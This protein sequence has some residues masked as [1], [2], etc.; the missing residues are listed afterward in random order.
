MNNEITIALPSKGALAD[1]TREFLQDRDLCKRNWNSLLLAR[2]SHEHCC[3][4]R[5]PQ[6]ASDRQR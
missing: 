1:P 4:A 2:W 3:S 6:T 5:C